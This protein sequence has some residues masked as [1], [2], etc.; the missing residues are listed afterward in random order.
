MA[1]RPDMETKLATEEM[2]ANAKTKEVYREEPTFTELKYSRTFNLGNYENETI[3]IGIAIPLGVSEIE[4]YI[5]AA[6][7]ILAISTL[8][9][10]NL[11]DLLDSKLDKE[12]Q[13]TF[14][15]QHKG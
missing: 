3:S 6:Q 4:P 11:R 7:N 15:A 10:A 2:M 1:I 5:K 13:T 9:S 8:Q 12:I 14:K